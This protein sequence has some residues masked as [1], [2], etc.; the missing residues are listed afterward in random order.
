MKLKFESRLWYFFPVTSLLFIAMINVGR[1]GYLFFVLSLIPVG[2]RWF[3]E[4]KV[5]KS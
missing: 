4:S 3:Y 1:L 2:F 5:K